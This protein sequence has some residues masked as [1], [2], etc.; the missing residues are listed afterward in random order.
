MVIILKTIVKTLHEIYC[1]MN[2]VT[3]YTFRYGTVLIITLLL[4]AIYFASKA[5]AADIHSFYYSGLFNDTIYCIKECMGS[6]YILPM[7]YEI[8]KLL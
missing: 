1:G 7:L 4:C 2:T 8:I 3:K 5:A 6:I